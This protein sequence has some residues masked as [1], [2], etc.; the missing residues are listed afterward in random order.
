MME[1]ED[2]DQ[3]ECFIE[4]IGGMGGVWRINIIMIILE[5]LKFEEKKQDKNKRLFW[6]LDF[7]KSFVWFEEDPK[8]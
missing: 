7:L 3:I 2:Q 1:M 4:Q 8:S 6:F 5:K